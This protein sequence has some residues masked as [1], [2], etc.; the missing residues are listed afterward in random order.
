MYSESHKK[1][2]YKYRENKVELRALVEEQFK[3]RVE[4]YCKKYNIS[5]TELIKKAVEQYMSQN[6]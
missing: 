6:S 5:Q 2:T 1:A 4:Q 3:K